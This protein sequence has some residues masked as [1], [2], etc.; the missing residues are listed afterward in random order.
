MNSL[1]YSLHQTSHEQEFDCMICARKLNIDSIFFKLEPLLWITAAHGQQKV[2]T[3]KFTLNFKTI[4]AYTSYI[5]DKWQLQLKV[6][7]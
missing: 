5:Y 1:H 3:K 6:H 7:I 4:M 2:Q